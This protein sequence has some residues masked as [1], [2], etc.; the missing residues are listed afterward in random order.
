MKMVTTVKCASMRKI[1]A[2]LEV[3]IMSGDKGRSSDLKHKQDFQGPG[4]ILLL[5]LSRGNTL[6]SLCDNLLTCS[7]MTST[8]FCRYVVFHL[9]MFI[10]KKNFFTVSGFFFKEFF[11]K[12]P[13]EHFH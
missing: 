2:G 3:R 1:N 11:Y 4:N 5:D 6:N 10:S 8:V 9:I 13:F 7:L 12:C